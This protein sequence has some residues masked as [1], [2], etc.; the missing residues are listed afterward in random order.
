ME[1]KSKITK[2]VGPLMVISGVVLV[3]MGIIYLILS[4][5]S[6]PYVGM[7]FDEFGAAMRL[8]SNYSF[9]G[10]GMLAGGS[11]LLL[12]G[13]CV[14]SYS[15]M[16]SRD[17]KL[18]VRRTSNLYANAKPTLKGVVLKNKNKCPYCQAEI[19]EGLKVCSEC[20]SEL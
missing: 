2:I 12:P 20:G 9:M 7:D 11:F 15:G 4:V 19:Q 14:L 3:V 17:S 6:R 5:T 18:S 1:E 8:S 10:I 13:I 16:L